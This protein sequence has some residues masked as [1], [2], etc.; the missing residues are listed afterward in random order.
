MYYHAKKSGGL[1]KQAKVLSDAQVKASLASVKTAGERL[2]ILLSAKA[3]LRACEIAALS[4]PMVTD[5][6]GA[7]SDVIALPNIASKGR[8]GGRE[9]PMHPALREALE[10]VRAE[11][12][13][14]GDRF[15][16]QV[17]LRD[18]RDRPF[19]PRS[20]VMRFRRLYASLGFEGASSH[21]GRRTFITRLARKIVEAGGS[22]RDVQQLAG[23][24]SLSMTQVYIEGNSDA[25]RRA[26]GMI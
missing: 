9:I 14:E 5:A 22:L 8:C 7:I 24:A 13:P 12:V 4:W 16:P 23:H 10:Q 19:H 3:G 6:E 21:S 15:K 26:V 25:K 18:R 20:I 1:A 17:I 2:M 11:P